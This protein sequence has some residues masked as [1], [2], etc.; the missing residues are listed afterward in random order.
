MHEGEVILVIQDCVEL[1]IV[2]QQSGPVPHAQPEPELKPT[3]GWFSAACIV[4]GSMVGSGIFIVSADITR[5]VGT[6]GLLIAIWAFAGL[7]TFLAA[8]SYGKLAAYMPRAGGQYVFLREAWGEIP[9]FLYG[10]SL[11]TVIQTGFLAAVAVAFTKYLSVLVPAITATPISPAVPVSWQSLVAVL[12]LL[13][14]TLFNCTGI[15]SGAILQNIFTTLKVLALGLLIIIGF[16]MGHHLWDGSINWSLV[17]PAAQAAKGN[18]L[19]LFAFASVGAL[20]SSDA[21]NYVTFIGGEVKA[22]GKSLPKALTLGTLTVIGLYLAANLA[23]LN[24]LSLPQI[25]GAPEDRVATAAMNTVFPGMGVLLMAGI[26]LIST[27]GCLNGMLLAG[28]RV[29]YA[30]AKDGLLFHKFAEV[31]PRTHSP[32]FSLWMQFIWGSVLAV[33]GK[34]GQ[35]LDYIVFATL[36][37][38]ILTMAGLLRLGRKIPQAVQM[39]TPLDYALPIAYMAGAAFIAFYLL[40]GDWFTPDYA[41]RFAHDFYHTKF[42]TSIAGL[43]LTLLG[44]PV[45]WL[46]KKTRPAVI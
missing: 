20:F 8:T 16:S 43:G 29:F 17:L 42:F 25:M 41:T 1:G 18:W 34:Y 39:H 37:F 10:W 7:L 30:M 40:F 44:L 2:A 13:G 26:I 35:L 36:I 6:G 11:L 22:P 33:S 31:H 38:Y 45:Y 15:K 14:L 9:A 4:A 32:N 3:L 46:W 19:T 27:F 24:L 21:W 28:A 23:Y 12:V 5:T